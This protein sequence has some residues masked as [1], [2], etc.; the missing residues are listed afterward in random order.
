MV[1]M[2]LEHNAK[3]RRAQWRFLSGF[4][5]PEGNVDRVVAVRWHPTSSTVVATAVSPARRDAGTTLTVELMCGVFL[6]R[7]AKDVPEPLPYLTSEALVQHW[8][9]MV[10]AAQATK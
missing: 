4:G 10:T 5:W 2:K 6:R 3:L 1:D 7:L 8:G 9:R